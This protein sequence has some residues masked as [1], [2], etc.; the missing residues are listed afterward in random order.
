MSH[1]LLGGRATERG[2]ARMKPRLDRLGNIARPRIVIAEHGGLA[3]LPDR[4]LLKQP[5]WHARMKLAPFLQE[6]PRKGGVPFHRGVGCEGARLFIR[7]CNV[8]VALWD[9]STRYTIPA[10]SSACNARFSVSSLR[11]STLKIPS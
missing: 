1:G 4:G 8:K 11:G 2:F 6:Q 9:S 10:L 3:A 7:C 5:R